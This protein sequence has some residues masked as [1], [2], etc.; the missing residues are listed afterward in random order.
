MINNKSGSLRSSFKLA[1]IA[2]AAVAVQGCTIYWDGLVNNETGNTIKMIGHDQSNA[3]WTVS[4]NDKVTF[5]WKYN[6]LEVSDSGK[7]YYFDADPKAVPKAA[8]RGSVKF[9][10]HTAYRDN[11]LYYV[12]E[13]GDVQPMKSLAS[14]DQ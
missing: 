5:A 13:G 4:A 7:S 9:T 8:V 14:C 12:L 6:C 3:N 2:A 10:V 11:Q 1:A